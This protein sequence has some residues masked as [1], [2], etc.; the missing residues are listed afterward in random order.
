VVVDA[1]A[2]KAI[3]A[4]RLTLPK[5]S[6][7]Q[8]MGVASATAS[9][10]ASELPVAILLVRSV[11]RAALQILQLPQLVDVVLRH[12][13]ERRVGVPHLMEL[14]VPRWLTAE[15]RGARDKSGDRSA[16]AGYVVTH[17]NWTQ[18][19]PPRAGANSA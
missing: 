5:P 6:C 10:L 14:N 7:G 12:L 13:P 1:R 15:N 9:R 17:R 3:D 16:I 4:E 2:S 11:G 8:P 19:Q 18:L